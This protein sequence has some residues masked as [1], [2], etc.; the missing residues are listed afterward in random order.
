MA[1]KTFIKVRRGILDPEHRRQMG[2]TIWLFLYMLDRADWEEGTV[3][4]YRDQDAADALGM[5]LS[6]IRVQRRKLEENYIDAVQHQHC[7]DITIKKWENPKDKSTKETPQ[8]DNEG[9]NE[10]ER[11]PIPSNNEGYNQGDSQGDNQGASELT[12]LHRIK[13][14]RLSDSQN[15]SVQP[16]ANVLFVG[17]F[18][19]VSGISGLASNDQGYQLIEFRDE[20]GAEKVMSAALWIREKRITKIEKALSSLRTALPE[21]TIPVKKQ[22]TLDQSLDAIRQYEMEESDAVV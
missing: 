17:E 3:F 2:E 10:G 9:Y 16:T 20:F 14:L 4:E 13:N 7:L 21:W 5:P 22:S 11:L 12:P 15:N 19:K 1:K 6:T 18:L 8:G